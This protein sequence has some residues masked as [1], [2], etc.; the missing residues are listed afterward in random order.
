MTIYHIT[1]GLFIFSAICIVLQNLMDGNK[2]NHDRND[3]GPITLF[4]EW[5]RR[6]IW[7][8]K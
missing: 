6:N 5:C 2:W 4:T 7:R 8:Q 3:L 1:M